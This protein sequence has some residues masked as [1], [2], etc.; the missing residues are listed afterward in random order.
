MKYKYLLLDSFT[1]TPFSGAQIAVFPNADRLTDEQKTILAKELNLP[2][3][4]FISQAARA[5][6]DAVLEIYTPQ[7]K[8]AFA[9]HAL[10]AGCYAMG[11]VG[12]VSGSDARVLFEGQELEIILGIKN[13]KVQISIPVDDNYDEYVPSNNELAQ[14]SGIAEVDLGYMSYRAMITGNPEPYLIVPVK[15]NKVLRLAQFNENKWQQS[16]VAPLAKQILLFTGDHPFG[17]VSFAARIIGKG[18]AAHEDPPIGSAAAALGIYLAYGKSDYHRSCKV[19]RGDENSRISILEVNV[20]KKGPEV[21]GIQL[22]G[23][24]V[25]VG[26]G[27]FDL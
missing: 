9:G 17:D 20:D 26:E 18:V 15:N 25:K 1:L 10:M 24:V 4:V 27:Y 6:C 16:F 13:Q 14:L 12:L 11:D 7:G 21:K 22:G 8:G 19:Q 3:I 2:E 5:S 23:N